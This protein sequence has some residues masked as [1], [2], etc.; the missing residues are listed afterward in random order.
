MPHG[1]T[2]SG[3]SVDSQSPTLCPMSSTSF[4]SGPQQDL[5]VGGCVGREGAHILVLPSIPTEVMGID[6]RRVKGPAVAQ[7]RGK[8]LAVPISG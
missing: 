8:V 6:T 3:L 2:L 1:L 7:G 4:Y 5:V